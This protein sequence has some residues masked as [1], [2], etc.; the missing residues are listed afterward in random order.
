MRGWVTASIVGALLMLVLP[1]ATSGYPPPP[2]PD[3]AYCPQTLLVVGEPNEGLYV[4]DPA[5]WP[6]V[7]TLATNGMYF[8]NYAFDVTLG[9]IIVGPVQIYS[10]ANGVPGLQRADP[11]CVD[12][13]S[14]DECDSW[15]W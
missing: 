13:P 4:A 3:H 15:W 8:T 6:G 14:W 1:A 2:D 9:I 11:I 12:C 7:F 10:E 5:R